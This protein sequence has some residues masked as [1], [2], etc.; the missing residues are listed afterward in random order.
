MVIKKFLL[1]MVLVS[2]IS[3][4]KSN[5]RI[6]VENFGSLTPQQTLL[7][8]Q[9]LNQNDFLNLSIYSA[10]GSLVHYKVCQ[11]NSNIVMVIGGINTNCYQTMQQ[12]QNTI[13][14]SGGNVAQAT[15]YA[16]SQRN[17]LLIQLK[18]K[19]GEIDRGSCSAYV[20]GKLNYNKMMNNTNKVINNNIRS[21]NC[22]A[23]TYYKNGYCYSY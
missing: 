16:N 18:C 10:F 5:F 1:I 2:T 19:T 12:W 9:K 23:G 13:Y 15:S 8:L 17:Q 14:F 4:A 20:N 11:I 21:A 22:P 6:L 7:I 3:L